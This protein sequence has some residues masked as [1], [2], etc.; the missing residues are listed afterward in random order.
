MLEWLPRKSRG[1][2]AQHNGAAILRWFHLG[3]FPNLI[4]KF[5]RPV[6]GIWKRKPWIAEHD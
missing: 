1:E 6:S 2:P 3:P 5:I 4:R